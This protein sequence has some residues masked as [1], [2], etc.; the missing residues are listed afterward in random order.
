MKTRPLLLLTLLFCSLFVACGSK[1]EKTEEAE[2][3]DVNV[4][5]YRQFY[6]LMF[7]DY[8]NRVEWHEDD[9]NQEGKEFIL[10][11]QKGDCEKKDCGEKVFVKNNSADRSIRVVTK[12]SFSIPNTVPYIANQFI[13]A[14]GDEVYLTCTT[15]CFGEGS[16]VLA[17]EIVVAEYQ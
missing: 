12:T 5:T 15:F 9:F 7:E 8:N 6:E 17:H 1:K 14:P 2:K 16:Y 3:E 13:M 10:I 4:L 11:S